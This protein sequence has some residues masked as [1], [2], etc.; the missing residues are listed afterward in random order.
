MADSRPEDASCVF[1][2]SSLPALAASM[3]NWR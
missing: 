1:A 3:S 2:T